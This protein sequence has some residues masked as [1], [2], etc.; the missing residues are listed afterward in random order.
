MTEEATL[1]AD[2]HSF[3]WCHSHVSSQCR[4][5]SLKIFEFPGIA[6]DV[7]AGLVTNCTAMGQLV[8]R[9]W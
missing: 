3:P 6:A 1:G 8:R 5:L 4:E 7:E 2:D 9:Q